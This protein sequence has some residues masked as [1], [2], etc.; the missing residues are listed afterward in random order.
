MDSNMP[1]ARL[2]KSFI[3]QH[4]SSQSFDRGEEYYRHNAVNN[5]IER[6]STIAAEVE[7]SNY[8][9]YQINISFDQGG[10]T[11]ASC[12]CPYDWGG[13]CKHIVAVLL[14][15]ANKPEAIQKRPTIEE[16]L[17]D[18][19]L[20]QLK[21][22][23]KNL[24]AN[25]PE[26]VSSLD[27]EITLL[28][29]KSASGKQTKT[30]RHTSVDPK[31]FNQQVKHILNSVEGYNEVQPALNKISNLVQKAQ[32]FTAQGDSSNAMIILEAIIDAYVKDWTILD[33]SSGSTGEFFSELD[34]A[35]TSAILF[36]QFSK[37]ERKTWKGKLKVW[38]DKVE[39]YGMDEAFEMSHLALEQHWDYAPL[40]KIL[41]GDIKTQTSP[42]NQS[43]YFTRSLIALRL[44][45]LEKQ[46]RYQ[47]YLYL[48]QAEALTESYLTMLVKLGRVEEAIEKA[49]KS[50]TT[51]KE[52]F[53]VAKA[54]REQGKVSEALSIAT[55][56]LNLKKDTA[57][58]GQLAIWTSDLAEG[59]ANKELALKARI[60]AFNDTPTLED[61]VKAKELAEAK[62]WT[63]LR[64]SLLSQM[65]K[66]DNSFSIGEKVDIYLH[67]KMIDEA[68]AFVE[69][70]ELY[71]PEPIQKVMDAA[72]ET[73]S[74]WV[75]KNASERAFSI[76]ESGRHSQY[77]SA[78][79]WLKQVRNAFVKTKKEKDWKTLRSQLLQKHSKKI[80]LKGMLEK[81]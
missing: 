76:I 55:H 6:G 24:V 41:K 17:T 3:R 1:I 38:R 58:V 50:L 27:R 70:L 75:I 31:P 49:L 21:S 13:W 72:I 5:L 54:L 12:S 30:S 20:E 18:L 36:S 74:E 4:A 34:E 69:K 35:L 23:L 29:A 67:E 22:L 65:S 64:K 39:D 32:H 33:G 60:I 63:K 79:E 52:A 43:G 80:K 37:E 2:S 42:K 71:N 46:K 14:T 26:L 66:N 9:P 8:E 59:L 61:Y 56:G 16:M 10:V 81:L 78:I 45:I 48:A 19:T 53:A 25:Q 40:V 73:H 68:I 47:E 57:T 11:D 28:Q 7:G 51:P 15:C 77:S 62:E 44:D